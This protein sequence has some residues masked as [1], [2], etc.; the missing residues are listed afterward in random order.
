MPA[1]GELS[2]LSSADLRAELARRDKTVIQLRARREHVARQLAE[3][4][5]ELELIAPRSTPLGASRAPRGVPGAARGPRRER[6]AGSPSLVETLLA[7]VPVGRIITP[8]EAK[9]LV[10]E[11]GY[12]SSAK[13]FGHVVAAALARDEHFERLGRGSYRRV[14]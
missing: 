12:V 2:A 8:A 7:V 4:E 9:D 14:S 5:A 6:P 3:I 13:T 10:A 11:A 1:T